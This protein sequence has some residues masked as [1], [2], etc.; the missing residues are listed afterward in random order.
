MFEN[1]QQLKESFYFVSL[2]VFNFFICLLSKN[3][4]VHM[5]SRN[6]IGVQVDQKLNE[7]SKILVDSSVQV[8]SIEIENNENLAKN[9]SF[10]S[11]V[12]ENINYRKNNEFKELNK[13]KSLVIKIG[14]LF[15]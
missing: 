9:E 2:M 1:L 15:C 11:Q 3:I 8:Q 7:K 6:H 4:N 10:S 5:G 14:L 13:R 12:N